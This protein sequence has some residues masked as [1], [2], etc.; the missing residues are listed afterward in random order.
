MINLEDIKETP[1]FDFDGWIGQRIFDEYIIEDIRPNTELMIS[2]PVA[3]DLQEAFTEQISSYLPQA[4]D[5]SKHSS[6]LPYFNVAV[7][8]KATRSFC[9][10]QRSH[11]QRF[12]EELKQVAKKS[13]EKFAKNPSE[14]YQSY[15]Y[16]GT[17]RLANT[18]YDTYNIFNR[19]W[20]YEADSYKHAISF[21]SNIEKTSKAMIDRLGRFFTDVLP[22]EIKQNRHYFFKMIF[23][24]SD[25]NK[26]L[27]KKVT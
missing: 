2:V 9:E 15:F 26:S 11:Y 8:A 12:T 1:L 23:D 6:S 18:F 7:W 5:S 10:D 24:E 13:N 17:G 14:S 25:F 20:G 21:I 22:E 16:D 27:W 3:R 19:H 4:L